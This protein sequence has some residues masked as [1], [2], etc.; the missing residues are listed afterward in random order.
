MSAYGML[1]SSTL[2]KLQTPGQAI[3]VSSPCP[4]SMEAWMSIQC[5][6]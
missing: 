6:V 5:A 4:Q 1:H 2:G 3:V